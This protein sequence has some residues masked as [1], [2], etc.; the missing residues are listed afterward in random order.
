[1]R[2]LCVEDDRLVGD[3][4]CDLIRD[5]G[6]DVECYANPRDALDRLAVDRSFG[7]LITDIHLGSGLDGRVLAE[8]A[9]SRRSDLPV[10]FVTGDPLVAFTAGR[11]TILLRKPC[12][13]G[14]LEAAITALCGATGVGP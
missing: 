9:R 13:L 3:I 10:I 6:H 8:D 11:E 12:T 4:L 2:I 14:T 5:L 1:M 7:L